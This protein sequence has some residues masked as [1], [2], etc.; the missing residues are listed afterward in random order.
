[1]PGT[2]TN[3]GLK[4]LQQV[5]EGGSAVH[6]VV[7]SGTF[8]YVV[9]CRGGVPQKGRMAQRKVRFLDRLG[10]S[11]EASWRRCSLIHP[12]AWEAWSRGLGG[13]G[14]PGWGGAE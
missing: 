10:E 4:V 11:G 13:L 12:G 6:T 9:T 1:M 2:Q 14:H 3:S 8:E 7:Y 5:A